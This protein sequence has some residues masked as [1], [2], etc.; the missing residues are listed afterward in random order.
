MS[1][2]EAIAAN[3]VT[4]SIDQAAQRAMFTRRFAYT[5][6]AN[7]DVAD[8][9]AVDPATGVIP[10]YIIQNNVRFAYD[11]TDTTTAADGI[12][13]LVTLDNK[14]YKASTPA[15]PWSVLTKGTTAQPASPTI[16]DA[17]RVPAGATGTDWAGNG[18]RVA[19]YTSS[20]W[21]FVIYNI[22]RLL[23]VE[24]EDAY[25]HR[26]D[27]G[28]W[29]AGVGDIVVTA[30]TIPLSALIGANASFQ[31]RVE[32]QTTDT[33][34]V[35]PSVGAAYI[36]GP[37]PTG[38]WVG[39]T[40]K[41]AISEDGSTYTIYTPGDGDTVYDKALQT[42]YR[43][44]STTSTWVTATGRIKCLM[45]NYAAN[46]TFSK[47]S[48]C[49]YVEVT[50]IGAGGGSL[51]TTGGTSSFGSHCSATGG[52]AAGGAA[53]SGSGGDLNL[54]GTV[55]ITNEILGGIAGVVYG[56]FGRGGDGSGASTTGSGGG[57]SIKMILASALATNETV[58][59]GAGGS[60]GGGNPGANGGVLVKEYIEF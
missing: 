26:D 16:G 55:G 43:W 3:P 56:A 41:L 28:A 59:V 40:N 36:V 52:A 17:Y 31:I 57:A 29:V 53:G 38:A 9:T 35:G 1:V 23:Y 24:D 13:C 32:N 44:S 33:P 54:T 25:Y 15:Y 19:I 8:F 37:A 18:G 27:S 4:G 21:E 10:L 42:Q 45:T 6:A 7:E 48:R 39:H 51:L 34:P 49:V 20:G 30:D 14:R 46:G 11:S 22:G 60:G 5:F 47:N 50:V 58:T 2:H 12:T